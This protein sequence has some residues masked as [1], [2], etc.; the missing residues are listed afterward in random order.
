LCSESRDSSVDC[1]GGEKLQVLNSKYL[2]YAA[3]SALI[4]ARPDLDRSRY[5]LAL[6]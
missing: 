3:C 5:K 6:W 2:Y 4:A 1:A